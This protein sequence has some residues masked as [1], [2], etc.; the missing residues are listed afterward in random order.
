MAV[1]RG[2]AY[3]ILFPLFYF[4]EHAL[5]SDVLGTENFSLT[6]SF[7]CA[8]NFNGTDGHFQTDGRSA[9]Q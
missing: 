1:L 6:A 8:I 2:I 9:L 3:L 5:Y 7:D 4:I